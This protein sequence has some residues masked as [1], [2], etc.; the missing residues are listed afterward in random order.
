M[1]DGVVQLKGCDGITGATH[2]C[3]QV[4][5]YI[6]GDGEY[7]ITLFHRQTRSS[8]QSSV[9]GKT[10]PKWSGRISAGQRHGQHICE[11]FGRY[12]ACAGNGFLLF[13]MA[14]AFGILRELL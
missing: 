4:Y 14:L 9:K 3:A 5:I 10:R 2:I 6:L 12:Y 7:V 11:Q 1:Q 8:S 13:P